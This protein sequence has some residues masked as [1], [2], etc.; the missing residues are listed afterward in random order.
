MANTFFFRIPFCLMAVVAACAIVTRP[1][2]ADSKVQ[3]RITEEERLGARSDPYSRVFNKAV[4][5]LVKEDAATVRALL[6]S[7]TVTNETRGPGAID[8]V[9][10][11]RFIPFFGDFATLTDDTATMPTYDASGS[12][13]IA[14][15]RSFKTT[16]GEVKHFVLYLVR[17]G[18]EKKIVV[19]NLL[20]NATEQDLQASKEKGSKR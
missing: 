14:I 5:A 11:D 7:T 6:S 1:S 19:G 8:A 4:S 13:G 9:I 12:T 17:E 20:L 15:A 2:V 3:D 18:P 16:Q 10:R